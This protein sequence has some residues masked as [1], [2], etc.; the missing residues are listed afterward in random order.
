M[1]SPFLVAQAEKGALATDADGPQER[2]GPKE[3]GQQAPTERDRRRQ[4][5]EA[6]AKGPPPEREKQR[7]AKDKQQSQ[8]APPQSQQQQ[9]Q[10]GKAPGGASLAASGARK[11]S[12]SPGLSGAAPGAPKAGPGAIGN[13]KLGAKAGP[14]GPKEGPTLGQQKMGRV[15]G[16]SGTGSG[17]GKGGVTKV[18]KQ[19]SSQGTAPSPLPSSGQQAKH[20]AHPVGLQQQHQQ[21]LKHRQQQQQRPPQG[22]QAHDQTQALRQGQSPLQHTPQLSQVPAKSIHPLPLFLSLALS[23]EHALLKPR[24]YSPLPGFNS[25]PASNYFHVNCPRKLCCSF[26]QLCSLYLSSVVKHDKKRCACL[27]CAVFYCIR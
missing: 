19:T 21:L 14:V 2:A 5:E 23:D 12:P 4:K 27:C 9:P 10:S 1:C 8:T 17:Q 15:E 26:W 16:L 3:E 18:V 13:G 22:G 11:A 20:G 6:E 24:P 25:G 7:Q